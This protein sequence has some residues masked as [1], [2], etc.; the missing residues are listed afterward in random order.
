MQPGGKEWQRHQLEL[1]RERVRTQEKTKVRR[2]MD[3]ATDYEASDA[4]YKAEEGGQTILW[5]RND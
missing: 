4:F 2:G 5:R 1:Q 3:A